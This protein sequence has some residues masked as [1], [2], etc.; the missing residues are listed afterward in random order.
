MLF[1]DELPEFQPGALDALRQPLETGETVIARANH[2]IAYPS[3]IQLVAAMNPCKCGNAAPGA[4][5]KRG[6]RCA[7]DYQARI[8]GPL[9]DRIDLQ[10]EVP[11]LSAADLVLPA[12]SEG[13]AEV[14]ARV[15]RARE[16]QRQRFVALGA[17]A[18]RTNADCSGRILEEIATPD[19]EGV[20]LL[21]QAADALHLSARG[22]H[23]TLRVART[24]ADLD[25]AP[26]VSR[27]H[28]AEA[29]SYRALAD[30]M[31]RAA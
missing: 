22:F 24:L 6:P 27:V 28:L 20:A 26:D 2:R 5:C 16:L 7:A 1:L 4:S 8:S 13:S 12:P 31:R 18:M 15:S 19:A 3:R 30:E 11:A 14:R 9:L 21:R 25:G 23:P 17:R 29:L 10:I